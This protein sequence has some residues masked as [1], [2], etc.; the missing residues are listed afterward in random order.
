MATYQVG[1]RGDVDQFTG[2]V[3][4]PG[5]LEAGGSVQS[6]FS[7]A[8]LLGEDAIHSGVR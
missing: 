8:R 2:G 1:L 3:E 7:G 6:H 4:D 5:F